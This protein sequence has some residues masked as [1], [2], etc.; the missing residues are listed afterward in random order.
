MKDL[1]NHPSTMFGG[2]IET[3]AWNTLRT[4]ELRVLYHLVKGNAL[5]EAIHESK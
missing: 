5:R 3:R 4:G 1:H 2:G